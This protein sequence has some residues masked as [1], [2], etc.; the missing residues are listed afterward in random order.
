MGL[1]FSGSVRDSRMT[2]PGV[3]VG[4]N[5]DPSIAGPLVTVVNPTGPLHRLAGARVG[6]VLRAQSFL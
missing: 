5:C 3:R 4:R 2:D 6:Q 1:S